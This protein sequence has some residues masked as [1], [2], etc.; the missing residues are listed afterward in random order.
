MFFQMKIVSF[1][2]VNITA[3]FTKPTECEQKVISYED[4]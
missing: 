1:H 3:Q 4:G 2:L